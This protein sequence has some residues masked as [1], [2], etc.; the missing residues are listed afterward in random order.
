MLPKHFEKLVLTGFAL[1]LLMSCFNVYAEVDR[2]TGAFS[3]DTID[4]TGM[5]RHY[6]S[7]ERAS[8][9]FG[10][11]WMTVYDNRVEASEDVLY[12]LNATAGLYHLFERDEIGDWQ[13][14]T[15][16][17]TEIDTGYIWSLEDET[18]VFDERGLLV[19]YGDNGKKSR[20]EYEEDGRLI[21]FITY[22]GDDYSV[23]TDEERR[24]SR[25]IL[26]RV[27][28]GGNIRYSYSN[29]RLVSAEDAEGVAEYHYTDNDHLTYTGFTDADPMI[30]AYQEFDG[31]TTVSSFSQGDKNQTYKYEMLSETDGLKTFSVTYALTN[32]GDTSVYRNE[33]E[34]IYVDDKF[35]YTKN[36]RRFYKDNLI[37]EATYMDR[38]LP[39]SITRFGETINY[40]YD[41][42][43]QLIRKES[44][45][46]VYQYTYNAMGKL[47][48][49]QHASDNE[50]GSEKWTRF[51]YSDKNELIGAEDSDSN[52]L[53]L[54]YDEKSQ[55]TSMRANDESVIYFSYNDIGKPERIE[56]SDLG[57]INVTYDSH[58]EIA[59]IKTEGD[60]DSVALQVTE[61]FQA[62]LNILKPSD[63]NFKI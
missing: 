4:F 43:D 26:D 45:G 29:G 52:Y 48:Y 44:E 47:S 20:L 1:F 13:G 30:I 46:R 53:S 33:Y 62:M 38:C 42:E 19:E 2:R 55:I 58:Q 24:V 9:L 32:Y 14:V 41:A 5:T 12:V 17:I 51:S 54:I 6:S 56:V 7:D 36:K 49:Y 60:S 23:V 10:L 57:A 18:Y 27:S 59:S 28:E 35:S 25:F 50:P 3:V 63:F 15:G 37:Y 11:G 22:D 34:D 31:R 16:N 21:R 40:F 61:A 39:L 8:G